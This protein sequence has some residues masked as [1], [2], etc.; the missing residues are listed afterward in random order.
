M[1]SSRAARPVVLIGLMASGKSTVGRLLAARLGCPFIDNDVALEER[2]GR[3]AREIAAQDG[4]D[5]LHTLEAETLADALGPPEPAVIAAAAAAAVDP[6]VES[7]LR[8]RDVV[9]LRAAP[10]VLAAR[11]EH[12]TDDGHRPFVVDDPARV[13][14]EQFAARDARYREL[15]TLIVDAGDDDPERVVDAIMD[16][17]RSAPAR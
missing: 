9:Y 7:A 14:A 15:A 8:G 3:S 4:A 12:E 16:G 13:L 11:I 5:A 2:T 17:L 6:K 10:E 1:T